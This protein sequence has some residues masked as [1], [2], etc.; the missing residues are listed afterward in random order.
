MWLFLFFRRVHVGEMTRDQSVVEM[1]RVFHLHFFPVPCHGVAYLA[2]GPLEGK[3][4]HPT[5]MPW[6]QL[7]LEVRNESRSRQ[8]IAFFTIHVV[9]SLR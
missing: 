6:V 2:V 9:V 1:E 5:S 4:C 7:G 8:V 3:L